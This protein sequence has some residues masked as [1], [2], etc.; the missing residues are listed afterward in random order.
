MNT[1]II[2]DIIKNLITVI[3]AVLGW[4]IAHYYNSVRDK[5]L[6][7][8]ELITNHLIA[9]YRILANDITKREE[10]VE[11]DEKLEAVIAELQLFGSDEQIRLTK[12]L[13]E[14]I[15]K[16]GDFYFDDLLN[17][18]RKDLRKELNLTPVNGNVKW[19]RH[20]KIPKDNE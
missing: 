9:A 20:G 1:G 11:R 17:S 5:D 15:V 19:L 7:R 13:V 6:K 4:R 2:L 3:I 14:D 18:L 8:R 16:G 12:K 10:S